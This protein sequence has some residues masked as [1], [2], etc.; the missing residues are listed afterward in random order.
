MSHNKHLFIKFLLIVL[1]ETL[2][3]WSAQLISEHIYP[4]RYTTTS[5]IICGALLAFIIDTLY[6]K[7]FVVRR[8][9]IEGE[10]KAIT[11]VAL[12]RFNVDDNRLRK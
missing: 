3:F 10:L 5:Y 1:V 8:K 7:A 6:D 9:R 11:D 2:A 12:R 4:I